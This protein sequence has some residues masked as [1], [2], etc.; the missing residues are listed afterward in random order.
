MSTTT[1]RRKA[2]AKLAG[3]REY[4]VTG[5]PQMAIDAEREVL[6]RRQRSRRT[7]HYSGKRVER[8]I[9][10]VRKYRVKPHW[11]AFPGKPEP[12]C[13]AIRLD[14]ERPQVL[15]KFT[16]WSENLGEAGTF[17][18]RYLKQRYGPFIDSGKLLIYR[19]G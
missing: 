3:I 2:R 13:I 6:R 10:G 1:L 14:Y 11:R 9:G 8:V 17:L 18:K 12:R 16:E 5:D 4:D 19:V 15:T 7:V